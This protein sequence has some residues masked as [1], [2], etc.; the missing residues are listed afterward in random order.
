MLTISILVF[1][2]LFLAVPAGY[3]VVGM[4]RMRADGEWL[5]MLLV[6]GGVVLTLAAVIGTMVA[7]LVRQYA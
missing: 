6:G 3:A 5:G 2:A 4:R 1:I 7:I